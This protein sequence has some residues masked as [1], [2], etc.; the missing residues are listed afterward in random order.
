MVKEVLGA[1]DL[2]AGARIL[3]CNLGG[4]GHTA[5]ILEN[6]KGQG[7]V[8]GID[9]D[10]SALD[11]AGK[12]LG[13]P[14]NF[15]SYRA[16]FGSL[17]ELEDDHEV[18]RGGFTGILMDLGVSSAQLDQAQ[19]GFS[20][21][22]D[23]PLDMRMDDRARLTA[24]E[25]LAESSEQELIRIF[26]DYGEESRARQIAK[27]IGEVR[28]RHPLSTTGQLADLVKGVVGPGDRKHHPATK[29]FQAL[30]IAVNDELGALERGLV[31]LLR[32]L[33]PGGRWVV[34]SYH[35][36]EDRIVKNFFRDR[37]GVCVCPR[38][39]PIC[40]CNPIAE[41]K[42]LP[43]GSRSASS[44]EISRNPRSRSAKMRVAIKL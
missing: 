17:D 9:C 39:L 38:D 18:A 37:T 22:S 6:L 20:F 35:S 23:A 16:N 24:A 13:S 29:V 4:G 1:L 19:R 36:L 44:E 12:R 34:L 7:E 15:R 30:R 33:A 10:S 41:L 8:V 5:A 2:K 31:S 28:V 42:V 40:V 11:F 25:I 26:R 3:D 21:R 14:S 32:L 43:G 27:K